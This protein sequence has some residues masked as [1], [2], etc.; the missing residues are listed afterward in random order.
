MGS[1]KICGVVRAACRQRLDLK[2]FG[3]NDESNGESEFDHCHF[4]V[5]GEAIVMCE[6]LRRPGGRRD[7]GCHVGKR[8]RSPPEGR[9][10][11][12]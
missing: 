11:D 12:M 7:L 8:Q 6:L 10:W 2:L 4:A 9:R 3:A 1:G 5:A